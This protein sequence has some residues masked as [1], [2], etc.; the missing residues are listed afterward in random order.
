MATKHAKKKRADRSE[1]R[2]FAPGP[3]AIWSG[4]ISFGLVSI[5]V[6]L[7]PVSQGTSDS[8]RMLAKDGT[9]LQRRYY[10]PNSNSQDRDIH[11]EHIVRGYELDDGTYITVSDEELE[12]LEPKKSH[13]IELKQFVPRDQISPAYYE[14]AYVLTPG[15]E[16]TK[17]YHLLAKAMEDTDRIGIATFVM[18]DKEYLVAILSEGGVLRAETLRFHDELRTPAEV[19]LPEKPQ[20]DKS[21][22]EKFEHAI[23]KNSTRQLSQA[24][25][26][27]DRAEQLRELAEQKRKRGVDLVEMPDSE[28]ISDEVD[29][30]EESEV[31]L[32]EAIR[33]SLRGEDG[34]SEEPERAD[35]SRLARHSNSRHRHTGH[36]KH[37]RTRGQHG[38]ARSK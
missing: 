9:P 25:L 34:Q 12:S 37:L 7:F 19:G 4:T 20:L 11:P 31:S 1:K 24:E 29:A 6:Q 10:N 16:S 23:Q 3:H 26:E 35:N 30:D 17:A 32:L 22:V 13:V 27:D 8:L 21:L 2:T 36:T 38:N 33:Q 28:P 5:P 18:R 14:R 15:G